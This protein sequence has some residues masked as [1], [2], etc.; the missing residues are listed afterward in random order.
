MIV[1]TR[2]RN[3][4]SQMLADARRKVR[5]LVVFSVLIPGAC[6]P[7]A[8][9]AGIPQPEE[10]MYAFPSPRTFDAPGT[11]FRVRPDGIRTLVLTSAELPAFAVDT[12]SEHLAVTIA[13]ARG[14]LSPLATFLG[15]RLTADLERDD[16][17]RVSVSG[18]RREYTTERRLRTALAAILDSTDFAGSGKLYVILETI[19]ADSVDILVAGSR[20]F[21][22][23]RGDSGIV[24]AD[25]SGLARWSATSS[26]KLQVRFPRPYRVFYKAVVVSPGGRLLE[27]GDRQAILLLPTRDGEGT[28]VEH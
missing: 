10:G 1:V 22:V 14:S 13:A 28:W 12:A 19:L 27:P 15:I 9:T 5:A 24:S 25:S 21:A 18:A 7:T 26:S 8:S 17:V 3:R 16:T 23:A 20:S 6:R 2:V 11:V 4:K